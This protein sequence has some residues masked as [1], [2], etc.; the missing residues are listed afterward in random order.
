MMDSA[1][2]EPCPVK[3]YIFKPIWR[4]PYFDA[5][6]RCVPKLLNTVKRVMQ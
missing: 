3:D 5:V 1:A 6:Q 4:N 2:E